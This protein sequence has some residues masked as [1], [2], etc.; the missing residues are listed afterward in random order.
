MVNLNELI[1]K[2]EELKG[3][4]RRAS[5]D[6]DNPVLTTSIVIELENFIDYLKD[7]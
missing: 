5:K 3:E 1:R 7:K 2:S 4:I 6:I